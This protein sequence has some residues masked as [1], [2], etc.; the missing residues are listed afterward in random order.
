VDKIGEDSIEPVDRLGLVKIAREGS[1]RPLVFI[2]FLADAYKEVKEACMYGGKMD[3]LTSLSGFF[4]FF[5]NSL[6]VLDELIV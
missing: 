5:A 6:I 4:D 3:C 1:D 2:P